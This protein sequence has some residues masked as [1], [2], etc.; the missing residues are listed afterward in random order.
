[1]DR[2]SFKL[3]FRKIGVTK[4]PC[5][6]CSKGF[7][8]VKKNTFHFEE[9][10][11]SSKIHH[12]EDW[13]PEWIEYLY[14]C[15]FECSNTV[16][17]EIISS[18]GRGSV[19][20]DYSY[21]E[22][23][24]YGIDYDEFFSP[25]YFTPHLKLFVLP[26]GTPESVSNEME[27]SFSLF[28]SDSSSSANHIRI[29]LEHLLTHLKIKRFTTFNGHRNYLA[30]HKRI[31]LLPRK[32]DHVKDIF[33]AIKWLGNAGSHS[34]HEVTMDDV[35]DAYELMDELLVEIF[36]NKRKQAKSLAK[37]INKKKGPK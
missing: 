22:E 34:Q 20:E 31:E 15:L 9:T 12:H 33:L 5:P 35:L 3:P 10:I 2:K 16:C 27:N 28:F 29:A 21:D 6:T 23:G 4:Y 18:S 32:Y 7:L 11:K 26:T 19:S 8:K 25:E 1:M 13:G 14:S 37:R 24:A 17:K 36:A 30:L